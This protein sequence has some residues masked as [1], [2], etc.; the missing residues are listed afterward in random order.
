MTALM[1]SLAPW[2]SPALTVCLAAWGTLDWV[3]RRRLQTKS[4]AQEKQL[5]RQRDELQEQHGKLERFTGLISR[6][7]AFTI[8]PTGQV[9]RQQFADA[10]VDCASALVKA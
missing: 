7:Q 4:A 6:L 9:P 2:L 3:V 5:N 1:N 10:L 8:S